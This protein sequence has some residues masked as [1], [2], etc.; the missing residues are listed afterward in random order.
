MIPGRA[1]GWICAHRRAYRQNKKPVNKSRMATRLFITNDSHNQTG[2]DRQS[3]R[4][5]APN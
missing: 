2:E 3:G 1:W 5:V 4:P